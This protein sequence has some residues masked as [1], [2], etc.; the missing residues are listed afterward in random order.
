MIDWL[1]RRRVIVV[2][3]TA[4]LCRSPMGQG[5]LEQA[6]R[7]AG[8]AQVY[9]VISAGTHVSVEG[10][11]PDPR[12]V[13]AM[14]AR[15]IDI[16]RQRAR[17]LRLKDIEAAEVV[18]LMDT[19]NLSA[20]WCI[21]GDVERPLELVQ[22]FTPTNINDREVPDPYFGSEAGFATVAAMLEEACFGFVD[23]L[24]SLGD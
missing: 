3:C 2:A 7:N 16:S 13:R 17:Q 22:T 12:A 10:Q 21:V 18:L 14:A 9:R 8:L 23:R 24:I 11:R 5:F 6:L 19:P 15:G 4:N 1:R 20:A